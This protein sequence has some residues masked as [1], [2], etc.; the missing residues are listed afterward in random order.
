MN[1]TQ[2]KVLFISVF[3][4]IISFSIQAQNTRQNVAKANVLGLSVGGFSLAYERAITKDLSAGLTGRFMFYDFKDTQT[5]TFGSLGSVDV[6]YKMDLRLIGTLPEVRLY[7]FSFFEKDA[8]EGFFLSPY[9]GYTRT[10]IRVGSLTNNFT[11]NGGTVIS[12]LELGGTIG[13]QFLIADRVT[14]DFF[15]GLGFTTFT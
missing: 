15:S 3:C 14:L 11:I 6:D 7:L 2:F 1:M 13:Y 9:A 12:F 5:F 10:R 4:L 8:P